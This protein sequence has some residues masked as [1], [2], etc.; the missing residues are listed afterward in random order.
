MYVFVAATACSGPAASATTCSAASASGLVGSFVI[1]R[2][3]TPWRRAASTTPTTSGERPDWLMPTT[4]AR[5][6]RGTTP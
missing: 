3:G 5:V 4:S 2:V 1:E 6:N